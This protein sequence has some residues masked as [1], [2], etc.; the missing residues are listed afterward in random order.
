GVRGAGAS[1]TWIAAGMNRRRAVATKDEPWDES[2]ARAGGAAR[3]AR[4][5]APCRHLLLTVQ[6]DRLRT[7][8]R[9]WHFSGQEK[10][11]KSERPSIFT[12]KR[13]DPAA[14]GRGSVPWGSSDGPPFST[15]QG[16]DKPA[17]EGLCNPSG[18]GG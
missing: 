16:L 11:K 2:S 15:P 17:A 14:Q 8:M 7:Y 10:T 18:V 9:S 12:A 13:L 1:A 4:A 3:S 6:T 5:L